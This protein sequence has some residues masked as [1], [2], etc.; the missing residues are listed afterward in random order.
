M[1]GQGW[2][3]GNLL[4]ITSRFLD[5]IY[6]RL[7]LIAVCNVSQMDFCLMNDLVPWRVL[8]PYQTPS[9]P[10]IDISALLSINILRSTYPDAS[11]EGLSSKYQHAWC[12]ITGCKVEYWPICQQLSSALSRCYAQRVPTK[13]VDSVLNS[14]VGRVNPFRA[15]HD[16]VRLIKRILDSNSSWKA[17]ITQKSCRG[18]RLS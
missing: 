10:N 2:S 12:T 7:V 15:R 4:C 14:E 13:A 11:Y 18:Q 5:Q 16:I 17:P 3:V 8:N 9:V 1:G 6:Y